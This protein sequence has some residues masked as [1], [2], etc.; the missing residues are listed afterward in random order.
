MIELLLIYSISQALSDDDADEHAI[1]EMQAEDYAYVINT[2]PPPL[3]A[4][5]IP[6]L[7]LPDEITKPVG[8]GIL[9]I[10]SLNLE[11]LSEIRLQHQTRVAALAVRTQSSQP[12]N[13]A[14]EGEPASQ[15]AQQQ[16]VRRQ[17]IRQFRD[18]LKEAQSRGVGTGIDRNARWRAEDSSEDSGLTGNAA[19]AAVVAT[20][21]A[22]KVC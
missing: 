7:R 15:D 1:E 8:Q 6:A 21:A 5:N 4:R 20:Q 13:K 2:L 19:N 3:S 9:E 22:K 16:S 11:P 17:L 18:I 14:A 10:D 12:S